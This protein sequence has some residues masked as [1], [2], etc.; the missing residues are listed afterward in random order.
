MGSPCLFTRQQALKMRYFYWLLVK[1]LNRL[2]TELNLG[3]LKG[4]KFCLESKASFIDT[5]SIAS[6]NLFLVAWWREYCTFSDSS[7]VSFKSWPWPKYIHQETIFP[8]KIMF[9]YQTFFL[10]QICSSLDCSYQIPE[11]KFGGHRARL[12]EKENLFRYRAQFEGNLLR[13]VGARA[14][15]RA[16]MTWTSCAVGMRNAILRNYLKNEFFLFKHQ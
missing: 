12:R 13:F 8:K 4:T 10:L 11:K 9:Y 2:H 15:V 1:S 6:F 3:Y 16:P 7:V 5:S 14:H